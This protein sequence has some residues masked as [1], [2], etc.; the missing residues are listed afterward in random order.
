MTRR[1]QFLLTASLLLASAFAAGAAPDASSY[2]LGKTVALGSP[3]RWDYVIY[4]KGRVFVAHGDKV[5]VV[6]PKTGTLLGQVEGIP[7]GTHGTVTADGKGYT[8]DGEAGQ[9]VVFDPR[10]FKV[11]KRI[12]AQDDADGIA[13]D[14][15]SGHIFV[16]EGDSKSITVID[17]KND[18]VVA[19]IQTGEGLEAAV[20][21]GNGK[22][23]VNGSE[24]KEMIRIDTAS[25][26]VDARWPIPDCTSPHGLAIDTDTHRLFVSCVN[27]VM[28]I[29]NSD[30]GAVVASVPIGQGTDSAA[31]DPKRK[32]A[33]SSNGVDGTISVI[34]EVNPQTFVPAGEI[35][36][37][38]TGRTMDIDPE[39]GQLFVAA[40][41]IDP[42]APVP[43]GKN[44]RPGRP[45]PLPGTLKL[46]I[47]DPA[48]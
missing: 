20:A 11:I 38:V 36:T 15:T 23:Y 24:K 40:A 27:K 3:E 47:F 2:H 42:N 18:Q 48:Q 32:L 13:L 26:K 19:T 46:M 5:A 31:F 28:T 41:D 43:P 44:G 29:V 37:K 6:D 4:D 9:V 16:I 34:R 1:G 35:K 7:G 10:T 30:N 17:P 45:K 8:D 33:F 21:G 25:N 14:P 22:L 39:T 12:K